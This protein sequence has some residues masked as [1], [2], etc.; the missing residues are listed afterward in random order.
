MLDACWA[1]LRDG[2]RLVVNAV[3]LETQA[4]LMRRYAALGGDLT[5]VQIARGDPV[6]PFHGFRPAMPVTQ[7][8][9]VKP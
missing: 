6:G 1:A 9:W 4:E 5:S 7:W 8:R 2:G 3:T